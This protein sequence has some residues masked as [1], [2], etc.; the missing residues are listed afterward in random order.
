MAILTRNEP[1]ICSTHKSKKRT[2]NCRYVRKRVI[3]IT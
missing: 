3:E 1:Q 2:Y